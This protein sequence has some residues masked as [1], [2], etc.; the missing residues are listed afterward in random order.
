MIWHFL[1]IFPAGVSV[2]RRISAISHSGSAQFFPLPVL[3]LIGKKLGM[4]QIFDAQGSVVPV[5]Y[6]V[7]EPNVVWQVKD[8][9]KDGLDAVVL[10]AEKLKK[11]RKTKKFR[12]LH[13]FAGSGDFT[14]GAEIDAGI[15][16]EGE[17]VTVT[18]TS[19]G[20]GF[21]GRVERHN[22]RVIRKTH[23]TK[24]AR[25]GSTGAN[26]MPGR[27]KPGIKMAG[28]MGNDKVTTHN[29]QIIKIDVKRQLIAIKGPVPGAKNGIVILKKQ[30]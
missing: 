3:G 7:C 15:F 16:A 1:L 20:H 19:K 8:Q 4:G 29:R 11:E 2:A 26:T 10:G 12:T 24:Y 25:H 21:A 18:G 23:G 5:T 28:R 9:A 22:F 13:Q 27:T 30:S 17:E 6:I 14:P